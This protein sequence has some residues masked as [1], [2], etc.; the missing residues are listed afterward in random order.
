MY[1][2]N[3]MYPFDIDVAE[4]AEKW[5]NVVVRSIFNELT[6]SWQSKWCKIAS[7][8]FHGRPKGK[9]GKERRGLA[10]ENARRANEKLPVLLN[11]D[12][13]DDVDESHE[14]CF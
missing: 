11:N 10:E 3:S 9:C 2:H 13:D 4:N 7:E 14:V 1:E 6:S 5:R 8:S 12:D